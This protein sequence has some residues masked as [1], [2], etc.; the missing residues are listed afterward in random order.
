M[1]SKYFYFA[2]LIF[3]CC[4]SAFSQVLL[5]TASQKKYT[6]FFK[7]YLNPY[8]I[9]GYGLYFFVLIV[10]VYLLHYIPLSASSALSESLPLVLSFVTGK[11]FFGEKVSIFHLLGA[12][13][14]IAGIVVLVW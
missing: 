8:V 10:N 6:S 4:V 12:A 3:T 14:I 5:K 7:Q 11:I 1:W 13:C 2:I 9:I